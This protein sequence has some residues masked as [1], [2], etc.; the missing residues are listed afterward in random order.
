MNKLINDQYK[1]QLAELHNQG[2]FNN[3]KDAYKIV[4]RFLERFHPQTILDFGCGHGALI[5][6]IS[7]KFPLVKIDGYDPGNPRFQTLPNKQYDAVIS[8]DAFEHIE[9]NYLEATLKQLGERIGNYGFFRIACYP[10]VKCLPD[11]RNAHLIIESPDWWR[12][13]ILST[14][15]VTVFRERVTPVDKTD[16][17]PMVK[18]CNYDVIVENKKATRMSL[19]R[20]V[21]NKYIYRKI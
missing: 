10:A 9:P 8:T 11:G 6:V 15:D 20:Y 21:L 14:M 13:K 5:E 12:E 19:P 17:Y 1:N 4:K 3:G 16:R 7:D 18:G 2:I